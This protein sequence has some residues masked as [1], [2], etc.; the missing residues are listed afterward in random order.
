[1]KSL[2]AALLCLSS[3][4]VVAQDLDDAVDTTAEVQVPGLSVK[5]RVS[6]QPVQEA[7]P[8]PRARA[9]KPPP[10]QVIGVESFDVRFEMKPQETLRLL[11][12]EGAHADI[13][14][15]DGNYVG[16]FDLPC[17]TSARAGQ[18]YRVVMSLNGGLIFDRKVELRKYFST[19]VSARGPA[20]TTVV[21]STPRRG[22]GS[23]DFAALLEA[24]K[25][26]SFSD[27]K[28]DVVRTSEGGLTVDQVGQLVDEFSFSAE[29]VKVVEI[30]NLRLVDRQNAFKLYSHFTFDGD[31]KAVKALLGK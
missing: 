28:L 11:S 4:A 25:G 22:G 17:E 15:D 6:G 29:K 8:P 9:P 30:T 3:T 26:E 31:K 1:M 2:F 18:F 10:V 7:P 20:T 14:A 27:A 12:P 16:G 13:W 21:T 24:V 23:V 19:I 5:M